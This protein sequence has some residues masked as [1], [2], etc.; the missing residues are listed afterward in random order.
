MA[1]EIGKEDAQYHQ[2]LDQAAHLV[3]LESLVIRLAAVI[4]TTH[5][6]ALQFAVA[7][8]ADAPEEAKVL[9]AAVNRH[10]QNMVG[11][12]RAESARETPMPPAQQ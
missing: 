4:E 6:G 9:N 2:Q 7:V 11:R 10:L 5:V 3:A 1:N 12:A 8:S